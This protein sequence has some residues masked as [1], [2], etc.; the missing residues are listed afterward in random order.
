MALNKTE[1]K[2]IAEATVKQMTAHKPKWFEE[3][4]QSDLHEFTIIKETLQNQDK[5]LADIMRIQN[6]LTK[7][8]ED[9]HNQTIPVFEYLNEI[10][11]GR[12]IRSDYLKSI[13]VWAGVII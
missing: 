7:T 12:K 4:E 9:Y 11:V 1:I 6:T 10:T 5:I 2:Q 8:Q 13:G 3:H